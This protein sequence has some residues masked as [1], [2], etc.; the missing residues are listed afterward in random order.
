MKSKRRSLK[1]SFTCSPILAAFRSAGLFDNLKTAVVRIIEGRDRLEQESFQALQAHYLC[2]AEFCNVRK[3]NEKGQVEGL[4]G[5]ARRNALVPVPHVSSLDE[6]NQLLLTWC[7]FSAARDK[8]PASNRTVH[9]VWQ[10]EIRALHPPP[11]K[12]FEACRLTEA[13]VGKLATITFDNHYS[14]P[15]RYVGQIVWIKVFVD[16]VIVVAQNHVIANYERSYDRGKWK[17]EL[18]HYLEALLRKPRVKDARVMQTSAVP[19]V[20]RRLHQEMHHRHGAE[21]DRGFV[22]FM[23]PGMGCKKFFVSLLKVIRSG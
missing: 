11:E 10:E 20:M 1:D 4:V 21:G 3:G 6:L 23:L 15:C 17:L 12:P 5:Y 9:D 19:N 18:D 16:H 13:E 7:D 22:R 2:K 8:V 14:V